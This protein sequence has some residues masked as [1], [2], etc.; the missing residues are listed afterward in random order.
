[1]RVRPAGARPAGS[2]GRLAGHQCDD[3]RSPSREA[4]LGAVECNAE[5]AGGGDMPL[6]R[7]GRVWVFSSLGREISSPFW[8]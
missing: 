4:Q 1:M 8:L 5:L 7:L 6:G 2:G 3:R